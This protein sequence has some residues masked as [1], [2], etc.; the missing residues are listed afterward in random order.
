[1]QASICLDNPAF[2]QMKIVFFSSLFYQQQNHPASQQLLPSTYFSSPPS[3]INR[4]SVEHMTFTP[5]LILA[6]CRDAETSWLGG[7]KMPFMWLCKANI[8]GVCKAS[9][10]LNLFAFQRVFLHG[11]TGALVK[12]ISTQQKHILK[13]PMNEERDFSTSDVEENVPTYY[14]HGLK[15]LSNPFH[16]RL[17][18]V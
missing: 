14:K 12:D 4:L 17:N 8:L 2:F 6:G 18:I 1:M 16:R 5:L 10:T 7:G 11:V 3:L 9:V 15:W 13:A